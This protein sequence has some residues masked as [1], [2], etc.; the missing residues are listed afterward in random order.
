MT[1]WIDFE[2]I[3]RRMPI[4][5]VLSHYGIDGLRRSGKAHLRG[6]CPL[7]AGEGRDT[8]HVDTAEQIFHC[9]SCR[10]G[11]S[12][13]DLVAA[14]EDC[15][16]PEA[17]QRLS[18]WQDTPPPSDVD[19]R[20]PSQ[21]KRTVTKKIN[22]VPRL[23]FRLRGINAR[24]PYLTARGI[25]EA[26]ALEFGV[27]YYCGPGLMQHR[28][29]IP[30][31]DDGGQLVGY[32]G[33][34]LDGAPPRYKFPPRFP[35]SQLLFNLHRAAGTGQSNVIVVEGFFDCL[36]VYQAGFRSVTALMGS[37][38]YEEQCRLLAARFGHITL[39]LDGDVTGRR[40]SSVMAPVLS[41]HA[42]VNVIDLPKDSQPDQLTEPSLNRILNQKGG[43]PQIQ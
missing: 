42:S 3:K 43:R 20:L 34:S 10:A 15:G 2:V 4:L 12:V 19:P 30:I 36:K 14:M 16:L 40:A 35:K 7:H 23:G 38:L 27:G 29:V 28:L 26:T 11:G 5:A 39:M 1:N 17:A 31:E 37:S 21:P 25:Q 22:S 33:R 8:F 6:R 18:G 13:L 41:R 9:F 32:C 24:H